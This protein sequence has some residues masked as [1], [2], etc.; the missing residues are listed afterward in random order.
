MRFGLVDGLGLFHME[1]RLHFVVGSI[2][3]NV[4]FTIPSRMLW[5]D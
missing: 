1:N 4:A 2:C 3:I 5:I